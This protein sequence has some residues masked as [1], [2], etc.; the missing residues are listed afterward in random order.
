MTHV[1]AAQELNLKNAMANDHL[2]IKMHDKKDLIS[3]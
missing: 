3:G 2:S 1:P